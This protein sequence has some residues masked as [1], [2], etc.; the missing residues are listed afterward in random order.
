MDLDPKE[1]TPIK[2][3]ILLLIMMAIIEHI[4]C[5]RQGAQVPGPCTDEGKGDQSRQK[6]CEQG[7]LPGGGGT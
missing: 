6:S 1:G 2:R 3:I 7:R 4:F 5:A